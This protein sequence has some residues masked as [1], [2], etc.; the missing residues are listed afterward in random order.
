METHTTNQQQLQNEL[1]IR[2]YK[3]SSRGNSQTEANKQTLNTKITNSTHTK[4]RT[5]R[6]DKYIKELRN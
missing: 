4:H 5:T 3:K 1:T 6:P 2:Q